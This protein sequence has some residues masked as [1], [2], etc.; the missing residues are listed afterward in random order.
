MKR[1]LIYMCVCMYACI[2]VSYVS[3]IE[4]SKP[5]KYVFKGVSDAGNS[6][7]EYTLHTALP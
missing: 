2:S 5:G 7:G 3:G 1:L 4:F 6:T